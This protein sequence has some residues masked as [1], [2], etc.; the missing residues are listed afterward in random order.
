MPL[1]SLIEGLWRLEFISDYFRL[2]PISFDR[3]RVQGLM[4]RSVFTIFTTGQTRQCLSGPTRQ[5]DSTNRPLRVGGVQDR[6][7]GG[8]I[9]HDRVGG[10]QDRVGKLFGRGGSMLQ[11]DGRYHR[12]VQP[13]PLVRQLIRGGARWLVDQ[14]TNIVLI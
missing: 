13:R 3:F 14:I 9:A 10:V 5:R 4:Y 6:V 7:G 12:T 2:V 1:A 11:R 8:M